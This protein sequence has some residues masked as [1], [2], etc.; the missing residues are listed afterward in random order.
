MEP[1]KPNEPSQEH[2]TNDSQAGINNGLLYYIYTYPYFFLSVC[3]LLYTGLDIVTTLKMD[4][5]FDL[6][7]GV[8]NLAFAFIV[9]AILLYFFFP[10]LKNFR[11]SIMQPF[12]A[13]AFLVGAIYL[14]ISI[15]I[16]FGFV[17]LSTEKC[18]IQEGIR[19][20]H[21]SIMVFVVWILKATAEH[22]RKIINTEVYAKNLLMRNQILQLSPHF[23]LNILN[24][25]RGKAVGISTELSDD[26]SHLNNFLTFS[27]FSDK[28]DNSL[29]FEIDV[30]KS[31]LHL[32]DL[33][34]GKSIFLDS[35]IRI[36]PE[37]LTEDIFFPKT[38]LLN[39]VENC[40]KHGDLTDPNHPG[41]LKIIL[42]TDPDTL[43]PVLLFDCS[44]PIKPKE[45]HSF[46]SGMSNRMIKELLEVSVP[47]INWKETISE[48]NYRLQLTI[49]YQK[50]A[51]GWYC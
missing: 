12:L 32:Q 10:G 11:K 42:N 22:L 45:E 30:I 4:L 27:L 13:L 49:N 8:V 39:L 35:T 44:N 29:I 36:A 41:R 6:W 21:Y 3:W 43:A 26:L 16:A 28:D 18:W 1:I 15:D 7:Q 37:L 51:S 14:K 38:A 40:Y 46:G 23:F 17:Q 34:F 50:N 24:C 5:H 25:I 9:S 31:F 2:G 48:T 20:F 47:K 19:L 33:R